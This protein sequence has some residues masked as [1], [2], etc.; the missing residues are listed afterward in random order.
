MNSGGIDLDNL[1]HC[2]EIKTVNKI[3]SQNYD[4]ITND[5]NSFSEMLIMQLSN[6]KFFNFYSAKS[7][8]YDK[9]SNFS[10]S[11]RYKFTWNFA[12]V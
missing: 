8:R 10:K 3:I 5:T 12:S 9:W 4:A 7:I 6:F 11:N 1:T 2:G